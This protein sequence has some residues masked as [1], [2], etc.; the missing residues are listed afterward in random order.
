MKNRLLIMFIILSAVLISHISYSQDR[1]IHGIVTT[2]DSIPLLDAAIKVKSTKQT[3]Y[4][5]SLG[6]FS[7][8]SDNEDMLI[9]NAHGF[10][11]QKVQ[12]NSKTKFAAVNMNLKPGVK[13][14]E[15]AIGYGH[16]T[17][18][19]KLNSVAS[20]NKD[21][22]DFSQYTNI[23]EMIRGRFAGV[24]IVNNEIIIR[25]INSINTSSAAL[26]V[27]DGVPVDGNYLNTIPPI[28]VKS[29]N[30]LKDG[31]SAIYG[32]R[33]ANGVVIIETRRGG[34]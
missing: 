7:V 2:F 15:Y 9:V 16:V 11:R 12:L 10:Y 4:S 26:V 6:R 25:G 20:L 8:A 27:V 14:R 5:D 32:S 21:D 19:D 31:A 1:V 13:S 17:D 23:Y 3:V 24:A 22:I 30:V 28:Q 33:G 29:I 18:E 34:D